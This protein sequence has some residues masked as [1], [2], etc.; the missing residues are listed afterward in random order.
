MLIDARE[1]RDGSR[2]DADL[3]IVG[4]GAAGIS[5]AREWIGAGRRVVLLESGGFEPDAG[6]QDLYA[7]EAVGNVIATPD[8][9]LV[10]T[11]LRF[12]GGSTN[13]WGGYCRPLA[14]LDFESRPW[15]PESGWPVD[16]RELDPFYARALSLIEVPP[17]GGDYDR[18]RLRERPTLDLGADSGIETS[19][20]HLS[21][22]RFGQRYRQEIVTAG[23]IA[24]YLHANALEFETDDAD[25]RV[26]RL[27]V[28]CL[29]GPR[30][31]VHARTFVLATGGIENARLL[32]LSRRDR[33]AGLGNRHDLVGRFFMDHLSLE[34]GRALFTRPVGDLSLYRAVRP[35]GRVASLGLITTSEAAQREKQLLGFSARVLL[36][37]EAKRL[38]ADR[39][40]LDITWALDHLSE[41][42][43]SASAQG[44]AITAGLMVVAEQAPDRKSRVTLG[45]DRDALG[46]P[47]ARLDWRVARADYDSIA[48]S[49]ELMARD[50]GQAAQG[51]GQLRISPEE[52]RPRSNGWSHHMG[53]TR[54]H[55][56]P[57]SGVVDAQCR[58]HG[59]ENLYV[60]G[61]SV[62][63]TGGSEGTTTFTLLAL[64]LRLSD[65]LKREML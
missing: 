32:L 42:R 33:V 6:T 30:F 4:A 25:R 19:M 10:R 13:H 51:R 14:P 36:E 47:R 44:E 27:Q 8:L 34:A 50:L 26:A 39:P 64:T 35:G 20:I 54:M 11:R 9:H 56:D 38:P 53:T 21:S 48:R 23:E 28:A 57:R 45:T 40:L 61:S 16:R 63:P 59:V 62:F 65:H 22:T 18:D 29:A 58:V 24:L 2:V 41:P 1:L 52:M 37:R 31:S 17:F 3:C 55:E 49:L 46:Q 5:L 7:G 60:A 12:F 15:V 43:S